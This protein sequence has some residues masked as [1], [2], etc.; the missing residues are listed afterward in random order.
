MKPYIYTIYP[1]QPPTVTT[2]T[3]SIYDMWISFGD[4]DSELGEFIPEPIS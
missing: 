1:D 4:I 3:E 2:I